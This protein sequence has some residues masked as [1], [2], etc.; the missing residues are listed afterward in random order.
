METRTN[1]N[2]NNVQWGL[3]IIILL[4]SL[5]FIFPPEYLVTLQVSRYAIHWMFICLVMGI[6]F[7]FMNHEKLLF[8][9]FFSA[10]I[11]A[12]FLLYSYNSSINL[13]NKALKDSISIEFVNPS[14]STVDLDSTYLLIISENPDILILEEITPEWKWLTE[15]LKKFFSSYVILNRVDPYGKAIFSKFAFNRIDTLDPINNPVIIANTSLMDSMKVQISVAN[16]LPAVT[17]KDIQ[18]L[19]DRL[20]EISNMISNSSTHHLFNANL[21]LVPWDKLIRD[22]KINTKLSSSRRD[23]SDGSTGSQIWKVLNAPMNEIYYS[24]EL[25]CSAFKEITDSKG[26]SIGLY[27]RYQLK[28]KK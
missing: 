16:S 8:I 17:R 12:L 14:L 20:I 21:N 4:I 7:M 26:N 11:L 19:N 24:N 10:G 23:Q 1:I 28:E 13:A 3:A 25:E 22:F 27:G 15:E 2:M 6:I 9:S 5:S 18:K